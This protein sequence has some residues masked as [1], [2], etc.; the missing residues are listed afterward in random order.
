[1]AEKFKIDRRRFITAAATTLITGP[2]MMIDSTHAQSNQTPKQPVMIKPETGD[3]FQM[4]KQIDAGV[5]NIGYVEIGP[6]EGIPVVLLH[7]W[8][9]D[10]HSY[11]DVAAILS[12]KGCRVIIPH[13]RGHGTT[14]FLKTNTAR[15]GQ[16]AS[17]GADLIAFMDALKLKRA[18]VAGYD[19]G[20][21]AA[22]VAAALWPERCIGLV[23]VNSYL[24]QDI[25]QAWVPISP[26]VEAG[27]W[28]QFY[29]LTERGCAGL[30]INRREIIELMW[31]RNSPKWHFTPQEFDRSLT[32]FDNPDYV[33]VV[34]HSYRHRLG[35][36]EG[37]PE[38]EEIE[39]RLAKLPVIKVPT[40]TLDGD[41][42][43]VVPATDGKSTGAKFSNRQHRIIPG[44]GHNLPQENPTA[45][46]A[47]VWKI[48]SENNT[49]F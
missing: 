22:C 4:M 9:Y 26:K 3:S 37:A 32:A 14:T 45:F 15:S 48:A 12:A 17:L 11:S 41:C 2:L 30:T 39:Q 28:Y 29:F 34:I 18:V 35:F 40:I 6:A 23:S 47:A 31:T 42:D 19:W 38:Y 24:I 21:R 13:L 27:F 44:A 20:G 10:I 49:S 43:G 8:P 16:Q 46:A 7:G 5:L 36:A 33:D 1:M 25:A